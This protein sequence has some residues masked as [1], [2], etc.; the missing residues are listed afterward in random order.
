MEATKVG[1]VS[2]VDLC[3]FWECDE[4][5]GELVSCELNYSKIIWFHHRC[6]Q[7][8]LGG[9]NRWTVSLL[10]N[11]CFDLMWWFSDSL[12]PNCMAPHRHV[13]LTLCVRGQPL[14]SQ[15]FPGVSPDPTHVSHYNTIYVQPVFICSV[16][17]NF[18]LPLYTRIRKFR[19]VGYVWKTPCDGSMK[20][21][22]ICTK[23]QLELS[24][25]GLLTFG[26]EMAWW[27]LKRLWGIWELHC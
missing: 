11:N 27:N 15:R 5:E 20:S 7:S 9:C 19:P 22:W 14:L 13:G 4:F 6:S 23:M 17:W 12:P 10:E 26:G 24:S 2:I 3:V 16:Y 1:E 8:L 18:F 25:Y 21:V